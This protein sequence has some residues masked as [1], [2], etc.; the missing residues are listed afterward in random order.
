MGWSESLCT[1]VWIFSVGR[2]NAAFVRSG[3]N[4][5]FLLDMG[6]GDVFDAAA[7]VKR[8]FLKRLSRYGGR[9]IA[10][11]V[12]SHPHADHISECGELEEGLDLHPSLLTCPHDKDLPDGIPNREKI[13]WERL[14]APDG[15]NEELLATYR[16]LFRQRNP[17]LQT[18]SYD[19]GRSIPNLEYGIYYVRPP[20]CHKLHEENTKYA[21]AMSILFYFRHG[22]HTILFP[23]D[24]TPE[25]M[26]IVLDERK[27]LEKRYTQFDPDFFWEHPSWHEET[28]DQPSLKALLSQRGLTILVAPH[29]GLTSCYSDRLYGAIAQ[30]K[31]RLVVISERRKTGSSTGEIDYHYQCEQGASGLTVEIE[32]TKIERRSL[33]T[34]NGHHILIVF[35]GTGQPRVYA[36]KDPDKLM[37]KVNS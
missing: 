20:V 4:Q 6:G 37:A 9:P 33:T 8:N 7:F 11:A 5:G 25:A 22:D 30:G 3:L 26:E 29:H 15:E 14:R 36:D 28:A 19:S 27:G 32:G 17:P 2:G 13:N 10:Q 21:N 34:V 35:A 31:P 23:G 24:I 12:L 18:I 1:H 16:K